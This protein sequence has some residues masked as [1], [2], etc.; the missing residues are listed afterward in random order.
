VTTTAPTIPTGS[1]GAHFLARCARSGDAEAFRHPAA[2][3]SWTSLTWRDLGE[4]TTDLAAGLLAL[5]VSREQRVAIARH[6]AAGER[7][8]PQPA[9]PGRPAG[10]RTGRP[11]VPPRAAGGDGRADRRLHRMLSADH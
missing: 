5:G 4:W 8:D 2:D 9:E 10:G 1:V 6:R 3:G 7:A 11:P